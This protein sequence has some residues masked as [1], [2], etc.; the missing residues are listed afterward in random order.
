M[1]N[2]R[3]DTKLL[4]AQKD[5]GCAEGTVVDQTITRPGMWD[6]FVVPLASRQGMAN[7]VY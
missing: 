5:E 6:F 7:P 2:K 3:V 4:D 1:V